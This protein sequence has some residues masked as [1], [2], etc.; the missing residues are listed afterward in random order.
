MNLWFLR[1]VSG[2]TYTH[3]DT[4][5][6]ILNTLDGGTVINYKVGAILTLP[7]AIHAIQ[8]TVEPR[9]SCK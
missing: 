7:H 9:E 6:A 5:I 4:L 8:T 3:I 1:Y 2:Q